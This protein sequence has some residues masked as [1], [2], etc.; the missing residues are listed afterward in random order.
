MKV[1]TLQLCMRGEVPQNP[2]PFDKAE[3]AHQQQAGRGRESR[4]R[5]HSVWLRGRAY[6]LV[7]EM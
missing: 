6:H 2:A 5:E 4:V 3:E 1:R 7:L